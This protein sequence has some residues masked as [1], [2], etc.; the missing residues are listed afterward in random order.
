MLRSD[1]ASLPRSC[2]LQERVERRHPCDSETL[3]T[4]EKAALQ[5]PSAE[6]GPCRID[7]HAMEWNPFPPKCEFFGGERGVAVERAQ[8]FGKRAQVKCSR[9]PW[10]RPCAPSTLTLS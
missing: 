7:G 4:V 9:S 3:R 2:V 1:A 6:E 10:S 8:V 5:N